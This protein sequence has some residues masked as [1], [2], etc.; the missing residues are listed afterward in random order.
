M[1]ISHEHFHRGIHIKDFL[2]VLLNRSAKMSQ[3]QLVN[4]DITSDKGF[5]PEANC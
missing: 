2:V 3:I 1:Q 5:S 4:K